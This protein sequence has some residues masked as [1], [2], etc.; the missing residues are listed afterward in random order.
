MAWTAW[1]GGVLVGW[2]GW[3]GCLGWGCLG[4]LDWLADGFSG[5][6]KCIRAVGPGEQQHPLTAA[7]GAEAQ[8]LKMPDG[9]ERTFE[10]KA[11]RGS[12]KL[13]TCQT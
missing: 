4:W 13:K 3:L 7:M 12:G 1:T 10:P 6:V 11:Q 9:E 2:V 5:L 8:D